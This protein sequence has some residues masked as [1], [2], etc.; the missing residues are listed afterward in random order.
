MKTIRNLAGAMVLGTAAILGFSGCTGDRY[1]QSTG[2]AIDDSSTTSHVKSRLSEDAVYKYS[3]VNVTTYKGTVQLSGF[4][5]DAGQKA[6]ATE[7]AKGV[8]GVKEVV[9]NITVKE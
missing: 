8:T 6:R 3:G 9:N 5:N 1:N 7:L 2:Q 4:V